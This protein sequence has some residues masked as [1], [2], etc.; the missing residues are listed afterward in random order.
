L[1][2]RL[3]HLHD[4]PAGLQGGKLEDIQNLFHCYRAHLGNC[5][6]SSNAV[7]FLLPIVKSAGGPSSSCADFG[8]KLRQI[9]HEMP[10]SP[11]GLMSHSFC[12]LSLSRL[13]FILHVRM[14]GLFM[15][16]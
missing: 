11:L 5:C 14:C 9:G 10:L 8:A 16:R 15:N 4:R 13:L 1:G 7:A 2:A 12:F 3:E 6:R